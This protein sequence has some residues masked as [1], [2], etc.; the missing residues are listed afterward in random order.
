MAERELQW[1]DEH[2]ELMEFYNGEAFAISFLWELFRNDP[3]VLNLADTFCL[4]FIN[5]YDDTTFNQ[6]QIPILLNELEALKPNCRTEEQSREL[7]AIIKFIAKATGKPW[8]FIKFYG[9]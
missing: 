5:P 9:D 2:G 8:T 3:T 1:E 4:Q 6:H 7:E